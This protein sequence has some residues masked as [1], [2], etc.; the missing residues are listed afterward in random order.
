MITG[1]QFKERMSK[2]KPNVYMGGKIIDRF[3]PKIVR[4]MNVMARTYD[5]AFDPEFDRV[6]PLYHISQVT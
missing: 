3:D 5:F 6:G 1:D 4:G 2:L